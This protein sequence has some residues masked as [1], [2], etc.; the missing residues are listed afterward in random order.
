MSSNV[1]LNCVSVTENCCTKS[2]F[3][4]WILRV[5]DDDSMIFFLLMINMNVFEKCKICLTIL[6]MLDHSVYITPN[7]RQR[8]RVFYLQVLG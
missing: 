1:L 7:N 2:N 3:M 8:I 4:A 5:N 6:T